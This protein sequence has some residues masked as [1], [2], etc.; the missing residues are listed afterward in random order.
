MNPYDVD[1]ASDAMARALTMAS[2]EQR[3][4]MRAM[5]Q[6]VREWNVFRWAGRLLIDASHERHRTLLADRLGRARAL[7]PQ[8]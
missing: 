5:R 6:Q 3:E 1:H 2:E 8:P 7:Q 4:R